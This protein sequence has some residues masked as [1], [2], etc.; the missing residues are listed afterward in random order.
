M[1][2]PQCGGYE[3]DR[4]EKCLHCGY[5]PSATPKFSLGKVDIWKLAEGLKAK[6]ETKRRNSIPKL[7]SCP[8]CKER[9]LFY[10]LLDD[11]F[12]CLNHKCKMFNT[13]ILSNT[14]EYKDICRSLLSGG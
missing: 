5:S 10:N 6:E 7:S 8:H 3:F 2:C 14:L 9:S 11:R 12:E 1:R 4:D 13:P